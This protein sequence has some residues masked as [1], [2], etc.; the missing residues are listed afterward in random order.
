M[1]TAVWCITCSSKSCLFCSC[2]AL[3][4]LLLNANPASQQGAVYS[5]GKKKLRQ[6][7]TSFV[8]TWLMGRVHCRFV[9]CRLRV[10]TEVCVPCPG[11]CLNPG[12]TIVLSARV[13]KYLI[14]W[15]V[16]LPYPPSAGH[17]P[18]AGLDIT[19]TAR[20]FWKWCVA[21]TNP[22]EF[23]LLDYEDLTLLK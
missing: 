18:S 17:Q 14:F 19:V 20:L 23:N 16:D 4:S 2:I 11:C 6:F 22:I 9:H 12:L 15:P 5:P 13:D 7:Y 21:L 1:A 10:W 8:K 3:S